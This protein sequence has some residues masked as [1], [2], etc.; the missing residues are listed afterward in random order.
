MDKF[1]GIPDNDVR[2]LRYL[3]VEQIIPILE[4]KNKNIT[5]LILSV[6]RLYKKNDPEYLARLL[7]WANENK[8]DFFFE[9]SCLKK[10]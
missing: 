5:R 2:I 9:Y 8:N 10:V 1:T 6:I 3:D 4:S 7:I